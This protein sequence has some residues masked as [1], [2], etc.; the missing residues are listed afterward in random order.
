[1]DCSQCLAHSSYRLSRAH[2]L[3]VFKN[4][5]GGSPSAACSDLELEQEQ[6][7]PLQTFKRGTHAE[8]HVHRLSYNNE[9]QPSVI[10][11]E[12]SEPKDDTLLQRGIIGKVLAGLFS[13]VDQVSEVKPSTEGALKKA[14]P[15]DSSTITRSKPRRPKTKRIHIGTKRGDSPAPVEWTHNFLSSISDWPE[16]LTPDKTAT[17]KGLKTLPPYKPPAD[18]GEKFSGPP[19]RP[20]PETLEEWLERETKE[21]TLEIERQAVSRKA[22][23]RATLST[24]PDPELTAPLLPIRPKWIREKSD[25]HEWIGGTERERLE[26][27]WRDEDWRLYV[28]YFEARHDGHTSEAEVRKK[29]ELIRAHGRPSKSN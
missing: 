1:M 25:E 11:H 16:A 2:A 6:I 27:L 24:T 29:L 21:E 4:V 8:V 23:N 28:D 9:S 26:Q 15:F 17:T 20:L 14:D 12:I 10:S 5:L 19:G 22:H 3:P 13:K 7:T 18:N